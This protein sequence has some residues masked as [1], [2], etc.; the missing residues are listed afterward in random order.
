M[1]RKCEEGYRPRRYKKHGYEAREATTTEGTLKPSKQDLK[2]A[3]EMYDAS[4]VKDGHAK[5]RLVDL[6][7]TIDII[8]RDLRSGRSYAALDIKA[9]PSLATRQMRCL[10]L[11]G[12]TAKDEDGDTD[13]D[14]DDKL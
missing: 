12:L 13:L 14:D 3:H 7:M 8:M 4:P 5:Q 10:E 11:L 6:V 9:V 1:R 2:E